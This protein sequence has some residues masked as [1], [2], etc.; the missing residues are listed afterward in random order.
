M[1]SNKINAT[2]NNGNGRKWNVSNVYDEDG[3]TE[4]VEE[5]DEEEDTNKWK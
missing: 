4:E 1:Y 2:N 5:E 3:N